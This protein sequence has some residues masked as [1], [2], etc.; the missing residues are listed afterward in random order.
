MVRIMFR[1]KNEDIKTT[2][3][4]SVSLVDF[5]QVNVF[6]DVIKSLLNDFWPILKILCSKCCSHPSNFYWHNAFMYSFFLK[7]NAGDTFTYYILEKFNQQ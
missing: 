2:S 6:W 1:G 7:K 5:D 4:S 3:T